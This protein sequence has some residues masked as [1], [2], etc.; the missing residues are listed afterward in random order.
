MN[1]KFINCTC[2]SVILIMIIISKDIHVH[3]WIVQYISSMWQQIMY[4]MEVTDLIGLF[5]C[6]F[7]CNL[8][9]LFL[10]LFLCNLIGLFLCLFLCNLIGLFLCLFLC[11]LIGLFL[12]LFLCNLI[13]LFLY[14]FPCR[15]LND[16]DDGVSEN[17]I[18]FATNYVIILKVCT[19]TYV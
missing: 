19:C 6:L 15:F 7:L 13:G 14:L 11:N 10:C 17:V 1:L 18:T 16:E 3:D 5:M 8:I 4:N 9:G 2:K 12:C